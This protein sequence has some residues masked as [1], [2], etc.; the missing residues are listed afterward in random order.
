MNSE[1]QSR[2]GKIYIAEKR[3]YKASPS[4]PPFSAKTGELEAEALMWALIFPLKMLI[5][6]RSRGEILQQDLL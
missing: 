3:V 5:T 4:L 2:F 1:P 6:R